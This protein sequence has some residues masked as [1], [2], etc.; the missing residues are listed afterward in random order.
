MEQV[1]GFDEAGRGAFWGP[2]AVACV[3]WDAN[4]PRHAQLRDSKKLSPRIRELMRTYVLQ[5]AVAHAVEFVSV[6]EIEAHNVRNATFLGW[7]RAWGRVVE[8]GTICDDA[9]VIVDGD[10]WKRVDDSLPFPTSL[11]CEPKA[12]DAHAA[13]AAASI[14]AKTFRDMWVETAV[15]AQ[16]GDEDP[17]DLARSKGYGTKTHRDALKRLGMHEMHRAL[18][19][20]RWV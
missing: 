19:C 20:R 14:L 11:R 17:Y 8:S 3:V 6:E 12:D 5:H 16:W 2:M 15:V 9:Q 4:M 10:A 1:V 18:F 13:V 7:Q